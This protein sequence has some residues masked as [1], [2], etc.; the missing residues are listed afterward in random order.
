[1]IGKL[2]PT[3]KKSIVIGGGIA[4]LIAAYRLVQ[5][6]QTVQIYE[7]SN[8]LGGLIQTR[9]LDAGLPSMRLA[10]TAAHSFLASPDVL[11]FC[12][13]LAV[14]CVQVRPGCKGRFVLWRGRARSL[15]G[16]IFG[17]LGPIG[18]LGLLFRVLLARF[19]APGNLRA[20][21]DRHLGRRATDLLLVPFLRGIYGARPDDL[22]VEMTFPRL[23]GL[24]GHSLASRWI[25]EKITR[26]VKVPAALDR[27]ARSKMVAPRLGMESLVRALEAKLRASGRCE[28][29]LGQELDPGVL[30]TRLGPNSSDANWVFAL[31]APALCEI[32]ARIET[33]EGIEPTFSASLRRVKQVPLTT[34]TVFVKDSV[35][36]RGAPKGVGILIPEAEKGRQCLGI[37]FNS[38]S[39]EGRVGE[40]SAPAKD[41][42]SPAKDAISSATPDARSSYTM[43]FSSSAP[44][45]DDL[46][47]RE[48]QAVLQS[49]G[50]RLSD[51]GPANDG[52]ETHPT[53]WPRALPVYGDDLRAAWDAASQGFF[54]K[55]GRVWFSNSTGQIS[56]R[57]MIETR[58]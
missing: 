52:W 45:P 2:D 8:R 54:A 14:D 42:R 32:V 25:G 31:P 43:M 33:L 19:R 38:S 53:S 1:M 21:G 50:C 18:F 22:N 16:G 51:D 34:I 58:F 11:K 26:R 46:V 12:E 30:N 35:F 49:W 37:L 9:V 27:R 44:L 7:K 28:I 56:L 47:R 40:S 6:G 39:W 20:W 3:R 5:A 36:R 41:T 24:P 17:L 13:E 55:P 48:F 23:V 10:E 15:P 57:G 29:F 4:G